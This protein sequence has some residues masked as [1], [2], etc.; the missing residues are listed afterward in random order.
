MTGEKCHVCTHPLLNHSHYR[1]RW[2]QVVDTQV[3]IDQ[4]LKEKWTAALIAAGEDALNQL[5]QVLDNASNELVQLATNYVVGK[6]LG[7]D[8]QSNQA[9]GT[10]L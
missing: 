10:E 2:E 9:F 4:S 1:V 5:N 3:S 6:P 8:R 7:A